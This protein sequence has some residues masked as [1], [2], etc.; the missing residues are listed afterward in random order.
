MEPNLS[1]LG[2]PDNGRLLPSFINSMLAC[3][4][5]KVQT[6]QLIIVRERFTK[7][8]VLLN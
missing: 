1:T 6:L 2:A 7:E 5:V 3:K 8:K 4:N